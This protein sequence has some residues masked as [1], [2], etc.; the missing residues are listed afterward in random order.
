MK[1]PAGEG[2]IALTIV[3]RPAAVDPGTATVPIRMTFAANDVAPVGTPVQVTIEAEEHKNVVLVPA[4]AVIREA[5]G[6]AVFVANGD[7]AERRVVTLG[8]T[9][10]EHAEIKS[11]IKAGE[12]VIVKGQAG[13]PD[14]AKI[15]TSASEKP[16][17]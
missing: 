10:G 2:E 6:T 16:D 17:K 14:G 12:P 8:L 11:G 15:S 5:D 4:E 1:N 13:L 7:K 3:S 9:D